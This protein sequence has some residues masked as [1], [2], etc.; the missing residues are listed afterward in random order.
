MT[1]ATG[2][3]QGLGF[4]RGEKDERAASPCVRVWVRACVRVRVCVCVCVRVST[5]TCAWAGRPDTC[6]NS[7]KQ[8]Y[9]FLKLE[10][11]TTE[12]AP[13][14]I[15]S[16][17]IIGIYIGNP[18]ISHFSRFS[19]QSVEWKWRTNLF[20]KR[21]LGSSLKS[22]LL[23]RRWKICVLASKLINPY[24]RKLSKSVDF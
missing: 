24:G 10:A 9:K 7:R 21:I 17:F 1:A 19:F 20:T 12:I 23:R 18:T 4:P 22:I 2:K 3:N 16:R 5:D 14:S 6:G 15:E 13:I 8:N 11:K